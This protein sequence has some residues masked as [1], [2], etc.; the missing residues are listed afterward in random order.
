[1]EGRPLLQVNPYQTTVDAKTSP[2]SLLDAAVA[3]RPSFAHVE[4]KLDAGKQ[5]LGNWGAM[6]WMDGGVKMDTWC[7]GGFCN[8]CCWRQYALE[9]M[10]YNMY[11]GAG[12]VAFGFD[13]PGDILPFAATH[14]QGWCLT[15]SSFVCGTPNTVVSGK[16]AGCC[17]C[18]FGGEGF[19][20]TT[21]RAESGTALFYAGGYGQ[22]Q[23]HQVPEGRQFFVNTGLFF[24]ASEQTKFAV[25]CPGN[26]KSFCCSGEGFVMK[27]TGPAVIYTQ[28]RD[29]K[30]MHKML[31]PFPKNPLGDGKGDEGAAGAVAGAV[32]S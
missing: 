9:H 17:M 24:A 23:R 19:F 7:Y 10:C 5:V 30:V 11:S 22:I 25:G 6:L 8:A 4:V 3:H 14:D 27:F 13:L 1:M 26:L 2:Q 32:G 20:L 12:T 15:N 18:L 31:N 28:N 29:P 21:I 16:F